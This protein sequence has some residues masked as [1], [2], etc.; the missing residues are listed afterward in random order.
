M[1]MMFFS[2]MAIPI[3]PLTFSYYLGAM[4]IYWNSWRTLQAVYSLPSLF[5]AVWLFFM[6]ESP[7]FV[8]ASGDED[9]ALRILGNIH[10]TNKCRRAEELQVCH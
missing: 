4:G 1:M 5:C 10:G 6:Q 2:V 3:I 8:L 9:W 7:K